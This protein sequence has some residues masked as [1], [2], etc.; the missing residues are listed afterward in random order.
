MEN[1]GKKQS[2]ENR[3]FRISLIG[4]L[5]LGVVSLVIGLGIYAYILAGQY[6]AR[7]FNLSRTTSVVVQEVIDIET[8]TDRVMSVYSSLSADE[9]ADP[10][11]QEYLARFAGISELEDYQKLVDI[12]REY[13][14]TN[15]V[16][17]LYVVAYSRPS[18]MIYIADPEERSE[19]ACPPGSWEEAGEKIVEKFL[20]WNGKGKLYGIGYVPNYGFVC[21]SGVPFR[22]ADGDVICYIA[23]DISIADLLDGMRSFI[24]L[25][26]AALIV[27]MAVYIA[28]VLRIMRRTVINPINQVADAAKKYADDKMS[29]EGSSEHFTGLDRGTGDEVDNLA[30]TMADMERDMGRYVDNLMTVTKEKERIGAELNMATDIQASQLPRLFPAFP[31]KPEIDIYATMTPAKEVG[32]DFYD[33]F[34][35][36]DDHIGLVIADVSGKGV[37]AALFMMV[38][39]VLIKSHLQN[40]ESPGEALAN[41]NSQL[42]EGNDADLFV[43]VWAAVF[44]LSTGKG[45]SANAGHEH[46]TLRRTDGVYELIDYPHSPAVAIMDG[47]KFKEREFCLNPGDSVFVYTDGVPEATNADK[48]LFGTDRMLEALNRNPDAD[49]EEVLANVK[50]GIDAFV[51]GAE[52]FDDITMLCLKYY[53]KALNHN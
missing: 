20:N 45:V 50:A 32:G 53:G 37:P 15:E 9:K 8:L 39:R 38:S 17:D 3:V 44:E 42:C 31:K 52:Q 11:S 33:F 48:E 26:T 14:D 18:T 35:I 34:S 5:V 41:V 7:A 24:L 40:G 46:P 6:I 23:A 1:R 51:E 2:L 29:G 21:S 49:P 19:L 10:S 47:M 4:G 36:D 30:H 13:R 27:I 22:N 25:Y 43:T 12:L 16:D 28:N